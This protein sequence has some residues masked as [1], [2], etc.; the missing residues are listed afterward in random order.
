M[1]EGV[2]ML[3]PYSPATKA[4]QSTSSRAA[5]DLAITS[6]V[7]ALTGAHKSGTAHPVCSQ[8]P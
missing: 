3:F 5:I 8:L 7:P 6:L 2:F 1:Q 4:P